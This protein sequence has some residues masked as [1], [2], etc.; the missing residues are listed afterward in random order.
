MQRVAS[1]DT[2]LKPAPQ[3]NQ[4]AGEFLAR[5]CVFL[6]TSSV[7]KAMAEKLVENALRQIGV[8]PQTLNTSD[9]ALL[10][11]QLLRSLSPF[12]GEDKAER[13]TSALRVLVG[14]TVQQ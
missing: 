14:G 10:S 12:V 7:G 8:T 2:N 3:T 9:I 4:N 1:V 13:L 11:I 5:K 6:L